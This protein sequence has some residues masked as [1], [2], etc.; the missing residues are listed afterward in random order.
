MCK[1][2]KKFSSLQ[3]MLDALYGY[4]C[5][6]AQM[7]SEKRACFKDDESYNHYDFELPEASV[8]HFWKELAKKIWNKPSEQNITDL[9]N[10]EGW[11]LKRLSWNGERYEYTAGQ[12]HPYEIRMIQKLVKKHRKV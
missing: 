3:E 4:D 5:I 7:I 10:S 12:D 2:I 6:T 8:D 1:T 11:W 9:R